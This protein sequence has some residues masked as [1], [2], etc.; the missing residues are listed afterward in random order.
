MIRPFLALA[1]LFT[2]ARLAYAG[3]C[4]A[5]ANAA[6]KAGRD[7]RLVGP[8]NKE[9]GERM[10][11]GN[12]HYGEALKRTRVVA[13]QDSAPAEFQ[14]AIA[15]YVAAEMIEPSPLGL[16]NLAQTY[17][18]MGDYAKA[19]AQYR[20]F[21]ETANPGR[22]LRRL[23]EC[24]IASMAAELGR[25][26]SKA[27]PTGPESTRPTPSGASPDGTD[28]SSTAATDAASSSL[29]LTGPRLDEHREP[30]QADTL[31]WAISGTGLAVAGV[32]GFLLLDAHGLRADAQAEDSEPARVD[33][34]ARADGRQTWG[35]VATAAG[36]ALLVAGIA[37][38]AIRA[39]AP[40]RAVLTS[41]RVSTTGIGWEARF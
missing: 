41:L 23:I 7:R 17:R 19:I 5:E 35:I 33:L 31:G 27:P 26:A 38:L 15:A 11:E 29:L 3:P 24:H 12:A 25:A 21:L 10:D 34:R 36:G 4:D 16:Y 28:G 39:D 9:A 20:Q 22:P 8:T 32:G 6:R 40:H 14:A 30:W 2:S 13:T 37:K 1:L 18:A